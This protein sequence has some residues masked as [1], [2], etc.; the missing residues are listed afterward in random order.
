[1]RKSFTTALLL[2]AA[3]MLAGDGYAQ[4][5]PPANTPPA[6]TSAAPAATTPKTPAKTS[7]TAAKTAPAPLTTRKQK[8]SYA[9]G[10]NIGTGYS[11]GLKK[12]SVEVDW[13]LVTQGLKDAATGGKT[14]LTEE[15]AKAV[16]NEVQGEV[17][18]EAQAK[19]QAAAAKNKADGEAFLAANKGKEGV[20]A[21]PDGLQYKILKAGDGP[22]PAATDSVVCNYRGTFVDGKEFDSSAKRGPATFEVGRVI[23]GWTEALQLMPVGSKWQLFIPSSL[24]YGERGE[25]RGGI[26]P[27]QALI[28]DVEL[29]SIVDKN[30]DKNKD[31]KK[32]DKS[33][34][35]K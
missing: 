12:Q 20:V 35:K 31:Q 13:N 19:A 30:A 28:F 21:L 4:Q 18:K 32:D 27:N 33:E 8:F 5:T 9:L 3:T 34:E 23:K 7:G 25:P 1:M 10:M 29:V 16:L 17:Q 26:E 2:A 6:T 11:Q 15:E 14:R 22:K 24:A